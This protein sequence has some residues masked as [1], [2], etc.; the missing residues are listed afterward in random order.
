M[1][2]FTEPTKQGAT[3]KTTNIPNFI[4]TRTIGPACLELVKN[5]ISRTQFKSVIMMTGGIV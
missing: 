5:K 2:T 4:G 1:F 3:G